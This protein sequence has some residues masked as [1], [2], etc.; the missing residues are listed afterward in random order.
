VPEAASRNASSSPDVSMIVTDLSRD[1]YVLVEIYCKL[2]FEAV[3]DKIKQ[4]L[5]LYLVV[6]FGLL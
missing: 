3:D 5:S 2:L 4:V 6:C 1:R